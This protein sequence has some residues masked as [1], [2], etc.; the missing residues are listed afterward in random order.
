[1]T[2]F[3]GGERGGGSILEGEALL[4]VILYTTVQLTA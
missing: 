1:M 3:R 4:E 2:L